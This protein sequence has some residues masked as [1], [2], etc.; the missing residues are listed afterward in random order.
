MEITFKYSTLCNIILEYIPAGLTR[1]E[2]LSS[3]VNT[4]DNT[5]GI[6]L[7]QD[8]VNEIEKFLMVYDRKLRES[9]HHLSRFMKKNSEWM[10]TGITTIISK[11]HFGRPA[12]SYE[13]LQPR[14]QK[15]RQEEI[16]KNHPLDLIKDSFKAALTKKGSNEIG[17]IIE[18]LP[19]ASPKRIKR[20]IESIPTP[21]SDT[22]FTNE[23]ALAL[24]LN[25][26]LT[27]NKYEMLRKA[28]IEK[29]G[30]LYRPQNR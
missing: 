16:I 21:K 5:F 30:E 2:K 9:N 18:I 22:D 19:E 8:A 4:I 13:E 23:D 25:L 15:K 17:Q 7:Q 10:E 24:I 29:N 28:L 26:G 20:M 27:R 11:K 6:K 12:K 3:L 14:S 1:P